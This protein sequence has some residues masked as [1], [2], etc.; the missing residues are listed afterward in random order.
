MARIVTCCLVV[1]LGASISPMALS[2]DL[3]L[4]NPGLEDGATQ[5]AW[6][7]GA[8]GPCTSPGNAPGIYDKLQ[9]DPLNV[10]SGRYSLRYTFNS[11]KAWQIVEGPVAAGDS[12]IFGAW[13]RMPTQGSTTTKV[14]SLD[15][16]AM[17]ATNQC[18]WGRS[19]FP[20]HAGPYPNWTYLQVS[21]VA[22]ADA[23]RILV[24]I[25]TQNGWGCGGICSSPLWVDD[26]SLR[27]S[28][29]PPPPPPLASGC[30]EALS[31]DSGPTARIGSSM[32]YDSARN[33]M[34]LF[35]GHD[36]VGLYETDT[37][38]LNLDGNSTWQILATEGNPPTPR[39]SH[40]AVY[41]PVR[42]RMIVFGGSVGQDGNFSIQNDTWELSLQGTPRWRQ[43]TPSGS[44]PI[45]R[46]NHTAIYD[47]VRDRMVVFGGWRLYSQL[48]DTWALS[49]ASL[50]WTQLTPT[51]ASPAS[52]DSHCAV[53]DPVRDRMIVFGGHGQ[54]Q[55]IWYTDTWALSLQSP[56]WTQLATSGTPPSAVDR[57]IAIYDPLRDRMV[58]WGGARSDF[59]SFSDQTWSLALSGV[60]EWNLLVPDGDGPSPRNNGSGAYDPAHDRI[61]LFGGIWG[62]W[63]ENPTLL[64]DTWTLSLGVRPFTAS[65]PGGEF[66]QPYSTQLMAGCGTAPYAWALTSGSL[67][68]GVTLAPDGLLSGTPLASG[69]FGFT[70]H[71]EDA[72]GSAATID[73]NLTITPPPAG[74]VSGFVTADGLPLT[75]VEITGVSNQSG[76]TAFDT[77]GEDGSYSFTLPGGPAVVSINLPADHVYIDPSSGSASVE[78]IAG[79]MIEQSFTLAGLGSI[80]GRC[81]AGPLCASDDT[82]QVAALV[83]L[84]RDGT[85]LV[86]ATTDGAGLFRFDGLRIG[87]YAVEALAPEGYACATCPLTAEIMQAGQVVDLAS[88]A[89]ECIVR[90][91][92]GTALLLCEGGSSPASDSSVQLLDEGQ[93]YRSAVTD[94]SGVYRFED[95]PLS[96]YT[97]CAVPPAGYGYAVDTRIFTLE[98]AADPF[99]VAPF[100]FACQHRDIVG[101]VDASCNGQ[102]NGYE[103]IVVD[104][105]HDDGSGADV[106]VR[107][108]VT[109]D[110]GAYRFDDMAISDYVVEIVT[111]LGFTSDTAGW[112]LIGEPGIDPVQVQPI[113][114]QCISLTAQPRAMGYWKH[115]VNVYLTGK[116]N[117]QESLVDLL[118]YIDLIVEHFNENPQH[119]VVLYNPGAG[120]AMD[121]LRQLEALLTVNRGGTTQDRAKQHLLAVLLNVVSAK[122]SQMQAVSSDG[123][124]VSQAITYCYDLIADGNP[125]NDATAQMIAERI[126]D[127]QMLTPGTIPAD[128]RL[129]TYRE[130]ST[131]ATGPATEMALRSIQPNPAARNFAVTLTLSDA[132]GA[133]LELF[134]VSGRSVLR[135]DLAYL[136]A[137]EHSVEFGA[138]SLPHAGV[139]RMR[140]TQ[141]GRSQSASVTIL[142]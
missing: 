4:N 10:H 27:T 31:T 122:L 56:S 18:I 58:V 43:L 134:D 133:A 92:T 55:T 69:S 102:Q 26:I 87:T 89:F 91:V 115:Q 2:A 97:V 45:G 20:D 11:D 67:P 84:I 96:T 139:Y 35:G 66:G 126:N 106:L 94:E 68:D 112:S 131:P 138:G 25:H 59:S 82:P 23:A 22:P 98:A 142:K 105:F 99:V 51:G 63:W 128:V 70:A 78:V 113:S 141:G 30:W 88:F 137:G 42:D 132:P 1:L 104:L 100:E 3:L 83:R 24:N 38:T 64:R 85:V 46:Y 135:R 93:T 130:P 14:L 101:R 41:D 34:I 72:S 71:V 129:I 127:N 65:I 90:D 110:D 121:R 75:G 61:V 111:P 49:L 12:V 47:P 36:R 77:S 19:T 44:L 118:R 33:R 53:Y 81:T 79:Q 117:A 21:Y 109:D 119:P 124:V 136:G 73:L 9:G 15:F 32:V 80:A 74:T 52:R 17:D 114:I 29:P 6:Q 95:V 13:V 125:G 48:G 108:T 86:E 140:L 37:W 76:S 7:L 116:G 60:P 16:Q 39:H 57:Q 120:N 103:G 40:V 62:N 54:P 50:Q 8:N 28:T 123:A 5:S 107:T